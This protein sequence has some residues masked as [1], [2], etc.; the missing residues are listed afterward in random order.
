MA[1]EKNYPGGWENEPSDTTPI[2]AATLDH[3]EDGIADA[4]ATADA[5][6]NTASGAVQP[7]DLATVATTGVYGDLI[8][9]PSIPSTPGDIGAQP[10]GDYATTADLAGKADKEDL[11]SGNYDDLN[12]LPFIPST[13]E[14]I[15]A[16]TAAQGATADTAVQPS[17]LADVATSGMYSDLI[18][19]PTIPSTAADVGA[20]ADDWRPAVTD[21]EATGTPS[22]STYLRGDGTWGTPSG[23]GGTITSEDITDATT[24]GKDVL[25]AA[26][27]AAARSAI[28]AG[29]SDLEIGT[30]A[31]TAM[32]GNTAIPSSP[33][34]VGA[35]TAAQGALADTAVQPTDLADVATTGAYADL[36]GTPTIPSTPG[37]I[38]AQPAGDY[39]TGAQGALADTAVQPADLAAVATSGAYGDLT[40]QPSIPSTPGDIGAQP[41]GDYA[42]TADLDD[43]QDVATM[44]IRV[45]GQSDPLPTVTVPTLIVRMAT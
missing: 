44:P 45:L 17:D 33:G 7:G 37:E 20:L 13:P 14:D 6:L 31:S 30:T 18:D 1:Y 5:A 25:T 19:Q 29:T 41:A 27:A 8:G 2:T 23:G 40:G 24:V 12:G 11:F 22:A 26:D 42:T 38:G 3:I 16:A 34:D 9:Q 39:A 15:G 21:I 36:T 4:A 35:A 28:G 43:K 10:A 32:A